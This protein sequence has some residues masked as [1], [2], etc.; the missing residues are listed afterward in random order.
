MKNEH[1][2]T[3]TIGIKNKHQIKFGMHLYYILSASPVR[4]SAHEVLSICDK[5]ICSTTL[6]HDYMVNWKIMVLK[7]IKQINKTHEENKKYHI[8]LYKKT[9]QKNILNQYWLLCQLFT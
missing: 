5:D 1:L 7:S 2:G 8:T 6:V 3:L 4:K 9:K